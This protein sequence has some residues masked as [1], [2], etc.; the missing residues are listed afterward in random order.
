LVGL[1]RFELASSEHDDALDAA[2]ADRWHT[3]ESGSSLRSRAGASAGRL[4]ARVT[5]QGLGLARVCLRWATVLT[6][7]N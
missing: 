4:P 2:T 6:G 5:P 3:A 1:A 7:A